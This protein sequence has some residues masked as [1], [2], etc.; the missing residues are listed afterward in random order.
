M[1]D[2]LRR[3]SCIFLWSAP[4]LVAGVVGVR[5]LRIPGLYQALGITWFAAIVGAAWGVSARAIRSG[6]EAKQRVGLVAG[7]FLLPFALVSLLWVGLGTPGEASPAENKMRFLILLLGAIA[8]TGGFA[9]LEQA[10][11]EAGERLYL[12]LGLSRVSLPAAPIS[13]GPAFISAASF[14][15]CKTGRDK[16]KRYQRSSRRVRCSTRF[17]SSRAY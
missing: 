6:V 15:R 2:I 4:L 11:H 13:S 7:L 8:V 16:R 1:S 10:L 14:L 17:Y 5:A 12:R 3:V 9:V